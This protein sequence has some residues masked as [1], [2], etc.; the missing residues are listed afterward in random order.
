MFWVHDYGLIDK[1]TL[2]ATPDPIRSPFV[3]SNF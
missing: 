2:R 1:R 3:L